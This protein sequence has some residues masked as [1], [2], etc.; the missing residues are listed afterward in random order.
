MTRIYINQ[1][2]PI[3]SIIELDNAAANHVINV[4]RM[5]IGEQIILFNGDGKEYSANI[6]E[7]SKKKI[8]L[9]IL[10]AIEKNL[11][12]PLKI[13]LGQGIAKGEK[14]DLIIQKA[15][16]LG[17]T[18]ITPLI[19]ARC[20]VHFKADRLEKKIEHWQKVVISAC[21]QCGRNFIPTI[22]PPQ[23]IADW[24]GNNQSDL[25]LILSPY[26]EQSLA[27]LA[28]KPTNISILIGPEG[29]LTAEEVE[30]AKRYNFLAVKL[31]PRILRTETAGLVVLSI[32][33][34]KWGDLTP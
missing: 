9:K 10:D 16:E 6:T 12:S 13:H 7:I 1:K 22:N 25:A 34:A 31:G 23:K 14:M 5:N 8:N 18:E 17:V 30:L 33:Q 24:I 29:G 15:V 28:A 32:L 19:T 11:E 21:E 4:L 27:N 26:A 3:D 2:L 20:N